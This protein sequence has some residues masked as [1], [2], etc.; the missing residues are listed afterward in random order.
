MSQACLVR[1]ADRGPLD[2]LDYLALRE[3]MEF[4]D[5]LETEDHLVL[6]ACQV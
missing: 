5:P 2:Q 1:P 4:E 6:K 3:L